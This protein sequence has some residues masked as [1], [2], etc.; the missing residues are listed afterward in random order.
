MSKLSDFLSAKKLDARRLLLAS[1]DIENLTPEDRSIRLAKRRLKGGDETAKDLAAKKSR[2][3]RA[4]TRPTLDR[5]L[6]GETLSRKQRGRVARAVN[7]VL[8]SK[9]QAA[10]APSDLF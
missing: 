1:K 10:A 4:L 8:T 9:K 2:S 6:R 5:A 3:G 7:A